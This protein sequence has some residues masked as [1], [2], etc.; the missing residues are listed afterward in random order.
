MKRK[1]L[2]RADDLGYSEAVNYGIEKSVKEGLINNVGIM[3]NM[4]ATEHGYKLLKDENIAF[5]QHTNICV[6][7]PLAKPQDIPSLVE[8]DGSF[9]SSSKYRNAESDFVVFEEAMIEIEAQYQH[10]LHLFNRKPDYFEGHAI[11]SKMFLKA[12]EYFA[13]ENNLKYSGIPEGKDPSNTIANDVS[14]VIGDTKVYMTMESMSKDYSPWGTLKK[15]V[16]NAHTDGVDMMVCHPGYLDDF[17]LKHS[18]LLIPR[19]QEVVML[20]DKRVKAFLDKR[21]MECVDYRML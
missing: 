20:V 9:K 7:R 12:L 8:K 21:G 19:T 17:I 18:S 5:G 14:I 10:F 13:E 3:L 15:M 11:A 2:L 6:G 4:Q 1:L 16:A